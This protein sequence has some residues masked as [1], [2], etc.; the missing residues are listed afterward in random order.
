SDFNSDDLFAGV[1]LQRKLEKQAFYMGGGNYKAPVTLVADYLKG[2][3]TVSLGSVEPTYPI[4]VTPA[5]LRRLFPEFISN[6]LAEGIT[7]IG[8]KMKGFDCSDAP[9][10]GVESR[11]SSPL[12][13]CRGADFQSSVKGLYPCGEGAGYAGGIMSAAVDGIKCAEAVL[14]SDN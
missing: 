12:R 8:R 10:T 9:L 7:L 5:D 13:I 1:K 3:K 4:G 2:Q 11:S 14:M 6:A